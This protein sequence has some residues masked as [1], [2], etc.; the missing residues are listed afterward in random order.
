M[1]QDI[2]FKSEGVLCR[3]WLVTPEGSK[4]PFACV[5]MAMGANYVKEFPIIQGHMEE[6]MRHG[7]ASIVFDY[8]SFGA[9]EGF[10]RL[11]L[12]PWEQV[13]D[14]RNAISLAE[15]LP[16]IDPERLGFWG[17]SVGGGHALTVAA[18]DPRVKCTASV[19][20]MVD[21]Y[22]SQR[23]IRGDL[24]F[25]KACEA[26]LEDRRKRFKDE[27]QRGYMPVV[28]MEPDKEL[29]YSP[30][31]GNYEIYMTSKKVAP[32]WENRVT[33]QSQECKL[34][35]D[36]WSC[37]PKIL[38]IPVLVIV[39]EGDIYAP[40]DQAIEAYN[41]IPSPRKRMLLI[42]SGGGQ[43]THGTVYTKPSH[44]QIAT[45]AAAEFLV[46]HLVK[47]YEK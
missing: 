9:S 42:P 15:T 21:G 2:E 34:R 8:R 13:E 32:S 14:C 1:R 24:G 45:K 47:P 25:K 20:P 10:P 6:F 5:I 27:T 19:V 33:I 4:P 12:D 36:V 11:H 23:V 37:V 38:G 22:A 28:S 29:C 39:V 40:W 43:V 46:E 35:Y 44:M 30:M 26:I 7:L 17:I 41:R 16:N 3:G 31:H 18:L